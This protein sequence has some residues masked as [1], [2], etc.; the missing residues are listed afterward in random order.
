MCRSR[1]LRLLHPRELEPHLQD[2]WVQAR[3]PVQL[4]VLLP[5]PLPLPARLLIVEQLLVAS[6]VRLARRQMP[7]R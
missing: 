2:L 1:S 7:E 4:L 5:A 3:P 6:G